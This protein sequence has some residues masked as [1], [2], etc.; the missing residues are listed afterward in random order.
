M[1]KTHLWMSIL[2][3]G[4]AHAQEFSPCPATIRVDAQKLAAPVAGWSVVA[5]RP[6]PHQLQGITFFD[7][8]PKE[9]ASL[10]PDRSTKLQQTWEFASA[11]RPQWLTCRYTGTT[12]VIGRVLPKQIKA[13]TLTFLANE[14]IGGSPVIQKL[15]CK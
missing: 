12:V 3:A 8:D 11:Q 6:E 1:Q 5:A 2:L 7:G 13:C 9:E 15:T 4:V 14:T 10:A